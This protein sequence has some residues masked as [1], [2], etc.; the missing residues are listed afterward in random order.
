M[1]NEFYYNTVLA[2]LAKPKSSMPLNKDAIAKLRGRRRET[3]VVKAL[4]DWEYNCN[5]SRQILNRATPVRLNNTVLRHIAELS[6]EPIEKL[7]K[8]LPQAQ[9]PFDDMWIEWDDHEK[10]KVFHEVAGYEIKHDLNDHSKDVGLLVTRDQSISDNAIQ[11]GYSNGK[12]KIVSEVSRSNWY[13]ENGYAVLSFFETLDHTFRGDNRLYPIEESISK[14]TNCSLVSFSL[15]PDGNSQAQVRPRQ[16]LNAKDKAIRDRQDQ[17]IRN[18]LFGETYTNNALVS[19]YPKKLEAYFDLHLCP[20]I[21]QTWDEE[22][23]DRAVD[24]GMK[25]MAGD[26]RFLLCTLAL[27]NY[28]HIV[29]LTATSPSRTRRIRFGAVVPRKEVK[30]VEIELPKSRA[31]TTYKRLF[32]GQGTPKRLHQRR[33][34]WRVYVNADGTERKPVWIAPMWV[35]NEDVGIIE[36]KYELKG[37]GQA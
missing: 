16:K 30:V 36:H 6:V 11:S 17:S 32:T 4:K 12:N 25:M 13:G 2:S 20:L 10:Q 29:K 31:K 8:L 33:G 37:R 24:V 9:L 7:M 1:E 35:G 21:I 26:A 5:K 18:I 14:G 28:P 15:F 3:Q 27:L 34:H 22:K 23:L 19:P